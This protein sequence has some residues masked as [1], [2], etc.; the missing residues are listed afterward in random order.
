MIGGVKASD[1][2]GKPGESITGNHCF[3]ATASYENKPCARFQCDG[4][5][6]EAVPRP[7]RKL[8]SCPVSS[9]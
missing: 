9:M 4:T 1:W 7:L 6:A 5:D 3:C 2:L 8:T